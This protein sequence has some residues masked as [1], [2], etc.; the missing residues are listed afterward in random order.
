MFK[1]ENTENILLDLRHIKLTCEET[2]QKILLEI[3][4]T[5]NSLI[6]QLKLRKYEVIKEVEEHF[7]SETEKLQN[8]EDKW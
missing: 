7:N 8:Y 1:I 2:K 5:F 3:E 6:K 4:Q